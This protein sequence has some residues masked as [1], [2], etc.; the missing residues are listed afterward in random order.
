MANSAFALP[1]RTNALPLSR[2]GQDYSEI[3]STLDDPLHA[4]RAYCRGE[5]AGIARAVVEDYVAVQA[6]ANAI[7]ALHLAGVAQDEAQALLEWAEHEASLDAPG[8]D[9]P[10]QRALAA[11]RLRRLVMRAVLL[12]IGVA[13]TAEIAP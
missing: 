9:A 5:Q 7:E 12:R 1:A 11:I 8:L 3:R 13:T 6:M 4:L 2:I 10:L